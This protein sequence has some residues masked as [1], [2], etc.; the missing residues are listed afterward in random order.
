[1]GKG[2]TYP[3][4]ICTNPEFAKTVPLTHMDSDGVEVTKSNFIGEFCKECIKKYNRCW[5]F[6]S[7]WEEDL[8]HVETPRL[9]TTKPKQSQQ[10]NMTVMPKR[11]PP[12]GWTEFRRCVT[13]K[14]NDNDPTDKLIIKLIRSISTQELEEM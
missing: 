11:Q 1:M 5:C 8:I 4:E 9:L 14:N 6:K 2:F 3:T 12:P 10:L 7:D 13:K